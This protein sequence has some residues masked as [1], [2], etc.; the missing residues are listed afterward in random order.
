MR[1]PVF[2][3]CIGAR[4]R[5]TE[6]FRD[7]TPSTEQR[8]RRTQPGLSKH[9]RLQTQYSLVRRSR[10][11]RHGDSAQA[12]H[13]RNVVTPCSPQPL[14]ALCLR[15]LSIKSPERQMSGAAGNFQNHTVCEIAAYP[16][17]ILLYRCGD[18]F[19]I[20]NTRCSWSSSIS[21]AVAI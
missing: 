21:I 10:S 2:V 8:R 20:F 15:E 17:T 19:G 9:A 5:M 16:A 11:T 13:H 1:H 6:R 18:D 7:N 3:S 14:S 4:L 12:F